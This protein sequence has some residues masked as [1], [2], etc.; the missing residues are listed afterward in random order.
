MC[1]NCWNN[2]YV[3]IKNDALLNR[4]LIENVQ[5]IAAMFLKLHHKVIAYI[6]ANWRQLLNRFKHLELTMQLP[7]PKLTKVTNNNSKN[8]N[9]KAKANIKQRTGH[10]HMYI[11]IH[12]NI[13]ICMLMAIKIAQLNG[14]SIKS[15]QWQKSRL[16]GERTLKLTL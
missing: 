15:V 7:N 10:I 2:I 11:C 5:N 3:P 4:K 6:C 8:N 13:H 16:R 9:T 14:C 1:K 12:I